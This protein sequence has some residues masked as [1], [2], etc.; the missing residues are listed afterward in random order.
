MGKSNDKIVVALVAL[1]R[2]LNF[3]VRLMHSTLEGLEGVEVHS[4]FF[5]DITDRYKVAHPTKEE[6]D[7]FI[8]Q[9]IKLQPKLVGISVLSPFISFARRFTKLIH[10]NSSA[11]VIWGGTHPTINPESCIQ[12][13]DIICLGEGEE[14][15]RDLVIHLR[16]GKNYYNI[17]NLWI[18]NHDAVI[19]NEM[20]PLVEDLDSIPFPAFDRKSFYFIDNNRITNNDLALME[21]DFVIPGSRGCPYVCSY[22]VNS[23]LRVLFRN[24]GTY[25]RSRSVENIIQEI[26]EHLRLPNCHEYVYFDDQIFPLDDARLTKFASLYKQE[27]GLPFFLNHHPKLLDPKVLGKLVDCGLHG[28]NVGIQSGSDYVRKHVFHRTS[29]NDEI[30]RLAKEL[31]ANYGDVKIIYDL[32]LDNPYDTVETLKET[33]GFLV[34]LPKPFIFNVYSIQFFPGYPI[35][36]KAIKDGHLKPEDASFENILEGKTWRWMFVPKLTP[37]NKRQ[38]L[39]NIVWLVCMNHASNHLVEYAVFNGSIGAKVALNYLHFKA[40]IFGYGI[41]FLREHIWISRSFRGVKY[42]LK[43]DI[44]GFYSKVRKLLDSKSQW[45]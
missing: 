11:L 21:P 27:V 6:E 22:C 9:I 4:I 2:F 35:T 30:V 3:P 28:I 40:K 44:P 20:R 17:K 12:E 36:K 5:K 13:T 37:Y 29:N 10:E 15:M 39:Q 25:F 34:Q 14:A 16:D 42:I 8:S 45:D 43:G 19:K 38:M 1:Y 7:L 24:L 26:K 18:N 33:I 32:L 41:E 31:S 23:K